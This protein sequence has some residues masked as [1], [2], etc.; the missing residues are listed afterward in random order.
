MY[1]IKTNLV[2]ICTKL[3]K[4]LRYGKLM[5]ITHFHFQELVC[6]CI[7]SHGFVSTLSSIPPKIILRKREVGEPSYLVHGTG[8]SV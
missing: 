2:A 4:I 7:Q 1:F 5:L 6:W 8:I 3:S